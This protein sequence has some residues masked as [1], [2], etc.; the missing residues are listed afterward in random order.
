MRCGKPICHSAA[1]GGHPARHFIFTADGK[2]RKQHIPVVRQRVDA[3]RQY[4][5]AVRGVFALT[6]NSWC[7]QGT[8][9]QE[10]LQ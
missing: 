7:R 2:R 1:G 3:G 8:E 5:D 6:Q 9:R 4:Q 10:R